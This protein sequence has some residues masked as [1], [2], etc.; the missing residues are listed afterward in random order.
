V[1][2]AIGVS[3]GSE[4]ESVRFSLGRTTTSSE[5]DCAVER[6]VAA[7]ARIRALGAR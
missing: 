7:V 2:R 1:L 4:Q 3:G 6:V 5:I